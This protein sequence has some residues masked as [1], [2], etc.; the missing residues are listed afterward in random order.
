MSV[1]LKSGETI[2]LGMVTCKSKAHRKKAMQRMMSDEALEK[3][4]QT[5]PFDG[6]RMIYGGSK[7]FLE[8]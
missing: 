5:I 3:V 7:T 1:K 2:L 6:S 4:W 8:A